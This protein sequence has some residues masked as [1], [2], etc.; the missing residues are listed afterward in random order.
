M[1]KSFEDAKKMR[2]DLE[3]AKTNAETR[4]KLFQ[5]L[6]NLDSASDVNFDERYQAFRD[7]IFAMTNGSN[8]NTKQ[9]LLNWAREIE[10]RRAANKKGIEQY[11]NG[12]KARDKNA[13]K[14]AQEI[15]KL[16]DKI[17]NLEF[18][19]RQ[20]GVHSPG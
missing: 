13:G 14:K 7:G 8:R 12:I 19:M 11:I 4:K 9:E 5:Q 17:R 3:K 18:V 16:S 1:W 2:L 10:R 20:A 6:R 15:Q